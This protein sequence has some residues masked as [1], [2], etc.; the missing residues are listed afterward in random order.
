M[1]LAFKGNDEHFNDV[2]YQQ[3]IASNVK[4]ANSETNPGSVSKT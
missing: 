4:I 3:E 1:T 2:V